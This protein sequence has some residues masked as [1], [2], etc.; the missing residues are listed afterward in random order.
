M[1]SNETQMYVTGIIYEGDAF[2]SDPKLA[3]NKIDEAIRNNILNLTYHASCLNRSENRFANSTTREQLLF[4][5]KDIN[6]NNN[7]YLT[8][9]ASN[10]L[11][12]ALINVFNNIPNLTYSDIEIR[13]TKVTT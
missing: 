10:E 5:M 9:S 8:D 11:R 1:I 4:F 6:Y 12:T 13:S 3:Y 7:L 2:P